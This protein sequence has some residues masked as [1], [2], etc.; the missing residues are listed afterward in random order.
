M[1]HYDEDD[2]RTPTDSNE[3]R[4]IRSGYTGP[5]NNR[6]YPDTTGTDEMG[7]MIYPPGDYYVRYSGQWKNGAFEGHGNVVFENGDTYT[8]D[9]KNSKFHGRG[10]YTYS[11]GQKLVGEFRNDVIVSGEHTCPNYAFTGT[12]VNGKIN[13]GKIIYADGTEFE[14]IFQTSTTRVGKYRHTNDDVFSGTFDKHGMKWLLNGYGEM[15]VNS[16]PI[17]YTY[18]GQTKNGVRHG[19]GIMSINGETYSS[20]FDNNCEIDGSRRV[21]RERGTRDITCGCDKRTRTRTRT[22]KRTKNVSS[23]RRHSR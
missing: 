1:S 10:A 22:S 19:K 12:F 18:R 5:K 6:G 2:V 20:K 14:G 7:V 4:A 8:G 17:K 16:A 21:M 9:F 11:D 23:I 13:Q 15:I 3:Q